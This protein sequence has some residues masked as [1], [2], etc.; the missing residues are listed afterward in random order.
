MMNLCIPYGGVEHRSNII[1]HSC[2]QCIGQTDLVPRD[3]RE[4]LSREEGMC[5]NLDLNSGLSIYI[6][7]RERLMIPLVA[8]ANPLSY[9]VYPS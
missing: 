2:H 9:G 3:S 8:M 6:S 4:V 7:K 1:L 5:N